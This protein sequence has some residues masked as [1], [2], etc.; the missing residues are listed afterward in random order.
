M[1][2]LPVIIVVVVVGVAMV[3]GMVIVVPLNVYIIRADSAA[4]RCSLALS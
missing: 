2:G 1:A 3:I 4:A